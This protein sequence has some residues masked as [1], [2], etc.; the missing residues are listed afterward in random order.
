M[1]FVVLFHIGSTTLKGV[2][3]KFSRGGDNG[4]K[5]RKLAK[6]YRKTAL[7]SLF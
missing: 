5:D 1:V 6:K 7:F 2:D 3:R 4:K